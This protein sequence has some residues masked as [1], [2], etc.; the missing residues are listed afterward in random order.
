MDKRH[1][2][3]WTG[4][5]PRTPAM[6]RFDLDAFRNNF[7]R[8]MARVANNMRQLDEAGSDLHHRVSTFTAK[9]AA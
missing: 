5:Q 7:A 6:T 1:R 3:D 9:V 8:I 2:P 4:L